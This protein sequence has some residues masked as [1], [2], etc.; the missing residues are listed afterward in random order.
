V[1][2]ITGPVSKRGDGGVGGCGSAAPLCVLRKARGPPLG[3]CCDGTLAAAV[4]A[5]SGYERI[6]SGS[7]DREKVPAV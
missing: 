7:A 2:I 6:G 4:P 1:A 5:T 3:G